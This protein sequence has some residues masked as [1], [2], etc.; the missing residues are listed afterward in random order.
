MPQH[1]RSRGSARPHQRVPVEMA[2]RLV[3]RQQEQSK[4]TA[5]NIQLQA[6]FVESPNK[7]QQM[8]IARGK[9]AAGCC[10]VGAKKL[11]KMCTK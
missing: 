7:R 5:Q 4:Y 9:G 10:G 8:K 6:K 11:R 1:K 3:R 2:D